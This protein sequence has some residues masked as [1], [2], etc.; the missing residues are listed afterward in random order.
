MLG[1]AVQSC[2]IEYDSLA[3]CWQRQH[4]PIPSVAM[5]VSLFTHLNRSTFQQFNLYPDQ[6]TTYWSECN[7]V[8][9]RH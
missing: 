8:V 3:H 9:S 6:P 4:P 5:L 1:S 7:P 2:C